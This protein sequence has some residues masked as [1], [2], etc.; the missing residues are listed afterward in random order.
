MSTLFVYSQLNWAMADFC[1]LRPGQP[2]H[3][4]LSPNEAEIGT[5]PDLMPIIL[6]G[7]S[8]SL[9]TVEGDTLPF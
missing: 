4:S 5:S 7:L 6:S 8:V 3:R 1:L 2:G 9:Q